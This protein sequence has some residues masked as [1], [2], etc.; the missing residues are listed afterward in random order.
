MADV[1]DSHKFALQAENEIKQQVDIL[2]RQKDEAVSRAD[3]LTT[4]LEKEQSVTRQIIKDKNDIEKQLKRAAVLVNRTRDK[5]AMQTL[6]DENSRLKI[7]LE[8]LGDQKLQNDALKENM[9]IIVTQA[10]NQKKTLEVKI[11]KLTKQLH[12]LYESTQTQPPTAP[13]LVTENLENESSKDAAYMTDVAD[14]EI[15]RAQVKALE[16]VQTNLRADKTNLEETAI[17]LKFELEDIKSQL[18]IERK[19]AGGSTEVLGSLAAASQSAKSWWSRSQQQGANQTQTSTTLA[20]HSTSNIG[21]SLENMESGRTSVIANT[22]S[23][24]Q[25]NSH[26]ASIVP[27]SSSGNLAAPAVVVTSFAP[28][29]TV[30][31]GSTRTGWWPRTVGS[32]AST[33]PSPVPSTTT[34]PSAASVPLCQSLSTDALV[35]Q[36]HH[37]DTKHLEKA[38]KSAQEEIDRLKA[39]LDTAKNAI[40]QH[41]LCVPVASNSTSTANIEELESRLKQSQDQIKQLETQLSVAHQSL[42]ASNS[43]CKTIE[44]EYEKLKLDTQADKELL[45]EKMEL[46]QK[47]ELDQHHLSDSTEK[48][49]LLNDSTAILLQEKEKMKQEMDRLEYQLNEASNKL[50]KL[51]STKDAGNSVK[52]DAEAIEKHRAMIRDMETCLSDLKSQHSKEMSQLTE[53]HAHHVEAEKSKITAELNQKHTQELEYLVASH[54]EEIET[55]RKQY[56]LVASSTP[57]SDQTSTQLDVDEILKSAHD[58]HEQEITALKLAHELQNESLKKEHQSMLDQQQKSAQT[59]MAHL[60]TELQHFK[61]KANHSVEIDTIDALQKKSEQDQQNATN[62]LTARIA[63]LESQLCA[64]KTF[65]TSTIADLTTKHKLELKQKQQA[66]DMEMNKHKLALQVLEQNHEATLKQTRSSLETCLHDQTQ[67]FSA[68]QHQTSEKISELKAQIGKHHDET[69]ILIKQI[70]A[71]KKEID[72]LHKQMS[73]NKE[74]NDTLIK[75]LQEQ[76]TMVHDDR[77]LNEKRLRGDMV[78]KS[79]KEKMELDLRAKERAEIEERFKKEKMDMENRYRLEKTK[80]VTDVERARKDFE[81]FKAESVKKYEKE[82]IQKAEEAF[83]AQQKL[84]LIETELSTIKAESSKVVESLNAKV[85]DL[86]KQMTSQ[87][88]DSDRIKQEENTLT[89]KLH[90]LTEQQSELQSKYDILSQELEVARASNERSSKSLLERDEIHKKIKARNDELIHA[91]AVFKRSINRLEKERDEAIS[92]ATKLAACQA[93]QDALVQTHK[94][95]WDAAKSTNGSTITELQSKVAKLMQDNDIISKKLAETENEMKIVERK[96]AQLVKDIQKQLI[97]ERKQREEDDTLGQLQNLSLKTSGST[98]LGTSA[99]HGQLNESLQSN[100]KM[101]RLTGDLLSLA[102]ENEVLNRRVRHAEDELKS[103]S[104]RI[105]S[106]TNEL[107]HK[108]KELGQK[109]KIIQQYILQDHASMLQPDTKLKPTHT[110]NMNIL[111][112]VTAMSKVDPAIL[113]NIN[114]KMQKLLEE[115]TGKML[116]M[117][118]ALEKNGITIS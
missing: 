16:Q 91:E 115:L 84:K 13:E 90:C 118:T 5:T 2:T 104:D 38:L 34:S 22:A 82:I 77:E 98:I 37:L 42:T 4:E 46:I 12:D 109:S 47:T 57:S 54:K 92:Q 19:R 78:E 76:L 112:S 74:V 52:D 105:N 20:A 116:K 21:G 3:S 48:I 113:A 101:E 17:V 55:I 69:A 70:D 25:P 111:S 32:T 65:E 10:D 99:S 108:E 67:Q 27:L 75:S 58:K 35:D 64:S 96:S 60:Q 72:T 39:E 1:N 93:E 87:Y 79:K 41:Q 66:I 110:F 63:E 26:R 50:E 80:L 81:T 106:I 53:Q 8:L 62:A 11:L 31:T 15:M 94:A 68:L 103:A 43:I 49:S 61:D 71:L 9:H 95:E 59:D 89:E 97:K 56:E 107:D 14:I 45:R 86:T 100:P 23:G 33:N 28:A 24:Q 36:P 83:K 18:D 102:Q 51:E 88:A 117:E 73:Q 44:T 30:Q 6:L 40:A 7:E 114:L 29:P 85:A